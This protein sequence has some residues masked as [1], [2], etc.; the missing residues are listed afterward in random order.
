MNFTVGA[1]GLCGGL[2][3]IGL[4]WFVVA[5]A[6]AAHSNAGSGSAE[7]SYAAG[8]ESLAAAAIGG[9]AGFLVFN[10]RL[11]GRRTAL[12]FLGDS[13]ST[14]IGF[15]LAWLAIHSTSAFGAASVSPPACLWI[16][17]IPLAD[18]ASC[19]LRRLLA[20]VSPTT[21]D[22]KH[23]HHLLCRRGLTIAESVF[24]IHS[25]SFL[26]GM[27][28]VGGWILGVPEQWLFAAFV[29]VLGSFVAITNIAWRRLD[30][31]RAGYALI[32]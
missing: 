28:G 25:L 22:L 8:L 14:L 24:V 18:S 1:D 6:T 32:A 26:C 9:L 7:A 27:V 31:G 23:F 19:I 21:P 5:M 20:G 4:F 12:V 3:I 16:M 30:R 11:P 15:I 10:L 29:F 2:G 17:T 13:G